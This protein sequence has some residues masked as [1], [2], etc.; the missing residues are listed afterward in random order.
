[1]SDQE[2]NCFV[3]CPVCYMR[4]TDKAIDKECC[5]YCGR[6][7]HTGDVAPPID[8]KASE[9]FERM[10]DFRNEHIWLYTDTVNI[11]DEQD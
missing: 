9:E 10:M 6:Q 5:H 1:M 2:R 4:L 8:R 11:C 7:W 3:Y